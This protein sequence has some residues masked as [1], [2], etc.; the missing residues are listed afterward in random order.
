VLN[1]LTLYFG[2]RTAPTDG[3]RLTV[4]YSAHCDSRYH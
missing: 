3:Y 2:L 1:G 4:E